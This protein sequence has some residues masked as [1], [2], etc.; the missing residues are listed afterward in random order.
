MSRNLAFFGS[1]PHLFNFLTNVEWSMPS[2]FAAIRSDG[3]F[4]ITSFTI[5]CSNFST[6]CFSVKASSHECAKEDGAV[7]LI[8]REPIRSCFLLNFSILFAEVDF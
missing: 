4:L 7:R 5:R 2:S 6:R 3:C 1:N 8:E